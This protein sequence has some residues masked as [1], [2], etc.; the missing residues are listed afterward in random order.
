MRLIRRCA[1]C[2]LKVLLYID[3]SLKHFYKKKGTIIVCHKCERM[4]YAEA[5]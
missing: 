1:N 2:K 4:L 5:S 3:E